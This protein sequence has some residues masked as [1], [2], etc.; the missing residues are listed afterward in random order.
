[1]KYAGMEILPGFFIGTTVFLFIMLMFQAIRLSEFVVVH[2]VNFLDIIKL[3]AFVMASFLPIAIPIAF[4]FALLIGVSRANAE[5]ELIAF[6]S[7]G[8]SK[9]QVY[10]PLFLISVVVSIFCLYA[11]LF[12]VPQGNRAFELL[13]YKLGNARVMAQIKPGVFL[14]GF[15]GMV[16]YTE[17]LI[18]TKN[19]MEKIFIYDDREEQTPLA[20]TAATGFLR[21]NTEK[22]VLTLRLN[23]GTI[24]IDKK[25]AKGVTQKIDFDI[26]DINLDVGDRSDFWRDYSL[27]SLS[28]FQ[29]LTERR[30]AVHD[31]PTFRAMTVELHR[32]LSLS[33]SCI[34]FSALGFAIGLFAQRGVRSTALLLCIVVAVVYW[35]AYIASHALSVA[36][37]LPPWLG[38]WLPNGFFLIVAYLL[39]RRYP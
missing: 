29:L 34:V 35:L 18:P 19:E 27:P 12:L 28:Y 5:G 11:S 21:N 16:L 10:M 32:R 15:H 31:L 1:M 36:G 26:Y 25:N 20:I 8:I 38:I 17:K 39:Y 4:L 23:D 33:F 3:S 9:S 24:Y 22:G 30:K 2:Q 7:T 14:E 13:I 37:M 6:Q